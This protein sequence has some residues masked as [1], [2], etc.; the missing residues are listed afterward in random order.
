VVAGGDRPTE[1]CE[2]AKLGI[3]EGDVGR[4]ISIHEVQ[5]TVTNDARFMYLP[6]EIEM[7]NVHDASALE[8]RGH[9]GHC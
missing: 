6:L 1:R 5:C 4:G 9:G 2:N 3:G 8:L 7:R